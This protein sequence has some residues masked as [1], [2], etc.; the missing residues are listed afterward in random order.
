MQIHVR[1][2]EQT[3]RLGLVPTFPFWGVTLHASSPWHRHCAWG[4]SLGPV[5]PLCSLLLCRRG[6]LVA[7]TYCLQDPAGPRAPAA[8]L[9]AGRLGTEVCF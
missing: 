4:W 3:L 5:H 7:P 6:C 1:K 9:L 2:Q 8:P